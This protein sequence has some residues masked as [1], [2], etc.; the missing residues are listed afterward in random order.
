MLT[1]NDVDSKNGASDKH[2][3]MSNLDN[4]ER[5]LSASM[6]YSVLNTVVNYCFSVF[7]GINRVSYAHHCTSSSP[8]SQE[9]HPMR[10]HSLL[11]SCTFSEL[12]NH[13]VSHLDTFSLSPFVLRVNLV[14]PSANGSE[15]D[16]SG[17]LTATSS[18]APFP[19]PL[20]LI[21]A[22]LMASPC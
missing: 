21:R 11:I 8:F 5:V 13:Y 1:D 16:S 20:L 7:I 22:F 14:S 12:K 4:H 18:V 3:Q 9:T 6:F 10:P 15:I 19:C 17:L 2:L